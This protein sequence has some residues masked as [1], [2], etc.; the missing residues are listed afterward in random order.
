MEKKSVKIK[1][2]DKVRSY[3]FEWRVGDTAR[4]CYVEGVV[5]SIGPVP[6]CPCGGD[7]YEIKVT[8]RVWAGADASVTDPSERGAVIYPPVATL[9]A[10]RDGYKSGVELLAPSVER[11]VDPKRV[12]DVE[13]ALAD[14]LALR[15]E[16]KTLAAR[17]IT[18]LARGILE[19]A[20]WSLDDHVGD[21]EYALA[22][23]KGE[24]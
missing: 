20:Y 9:Y 5:E 3:D 18:G 23:A 14:T 8:R 10:E 2:G 13:A 1:V 16:V 11:P 24:V 12:A 7:H 21:L 6:S 22:R 15:N 17:A 4:E 19:R